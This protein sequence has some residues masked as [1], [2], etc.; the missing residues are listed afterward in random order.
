MVFWILLVHHELF[1][2]CQF[3]TT[4]SPYSWRPFLI[5]ISEKRNQRESALL[6]LPAELRNR[7][8]KFV[9]FHDDGILPNGQYLDFPASRN[10]PLWRVSRQLHLETWRY[11]YSALN[12]RRFPTWLPLPHL[13]AIRFLEISSVDEA[14]W[15]NSKYLTN[16]YSLEKLYLPNSPDTLFEVDSFQRAFKEAWP[17]REI[18]VIEG[19]HS[20][21]Q[22]RSDKYMTMV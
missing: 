16:F 1:R 20:C 6:R 17:C 9:Y 12:F 21:P 22:C 18:D 15:H 19:V 5:L 2:Q 7:I 10:T 4:K 11:F 3:H 14:Y 8:Y 13:Q